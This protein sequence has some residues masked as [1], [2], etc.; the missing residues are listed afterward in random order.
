MDPIELIKED[1]R[2]VEALFEEYEAFGEDA[3]IQKGELV[4][5]IIDELEAHTE[6]E[7]TIAYPVFRDAADTEGEKKVEE[8]YAEHDVA[9]N[10]MDELKSLDPQDPQFAAKVQVLKE[11]IEHHVEEEETDLLPSAEENVS[12]EEMARIGQEMQ[13]FKDARDDEAL[14]AASEAEL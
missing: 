1:H 3:Y 8:A 9:K 10:I 5:A 12:P 2:R 6:M 14:D 7:E 11:S 4:E 13:A